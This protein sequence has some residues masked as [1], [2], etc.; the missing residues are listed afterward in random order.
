MKLLGIISVGFDVTDQQL[1]SVFAFVRYWRKN[2]STMRQLFVDFKKQVLCSILVEF[3]VPMELV[4]LIKTC[5]NETFVC[6]Q[7]FR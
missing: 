3:G 5:L 4:R 2:V 1:V 6:Q 7:S